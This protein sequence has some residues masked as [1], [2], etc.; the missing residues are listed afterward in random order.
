[1]ERD[2]AA[3]HWYF[4]YKYIGDDLVLIEIV[5]DN[6]VSFLAD[7]TEDQI[8]EIVPIYADCPLY[9]FQYYIK[10]QLNFTTMEMETI[11]EKYEIYIA[12]EWTLVEEYDADSATGIMLEKLVNWEFTLN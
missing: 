1:M 5:S 8:S 6:S 2:G 9:D 3:D 4:T 12:N 11:E 10:K 7:V